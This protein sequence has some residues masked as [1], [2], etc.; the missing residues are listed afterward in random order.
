MFIDLAINLALK[1]MDIFLIKN[2]RKQKMLET[3]EKFMEQFRETTSKNVKI[4]R[5]YDE[6]LDLLRKKRDKN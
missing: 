2:K 5:R 6:Q 3:L 4:K 1:L